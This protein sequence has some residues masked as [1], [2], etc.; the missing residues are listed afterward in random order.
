MCCKR[1]QKRLQIEFGI[2]RKLIFD[3]LE[4]MQNEFD[5]NGFSRLFKCVD[6]LT[7]KIVVRKTVELKDG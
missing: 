1:S 3:A 7:W 6:F 5:G 2:D 4:V